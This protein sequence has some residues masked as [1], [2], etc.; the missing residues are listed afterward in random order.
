MTLR[1]L[2]LTAVAAA[3]LSITPAHAAFHL[4]R[5]DQIYSNSDGSVQYIVIRES[6]GTN[7]ENFWAG[8][9]LRTTNAAG[10]VKSFQFPSNLPSSNTASRSVL[11]ATP[12]FAAMNL[13][14]P[15]FT[16]PARF[17]P[18][19]GGTLDYASGT[20]RINLPPLPTDGATAIDRNG[21]PVPGTPKNFSNATGTMT[22]MVVTSVEFYNASLDHYFISALAPDIDALDSGRISGWARTG[23]VFGVFPSQIA[24]GAGVT[25][26]CRIIIPPPH[27][28]SHFFGRSLQ[29]CTD[30]LAKFPFMSQETANAFFITLPVAG[31]CPAGT[32][33]VY[34]VFSNRVD[35]NHRYM[36]DRTLRDQMAAMGWT[37][38]GDGP[39][40]VVMCAPPAP[41]ATVS[42]AAAMDSGMP[43]PP[44]YG[45]YGGP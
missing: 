31:V 40:F 43:M 42:A 25:P 35:A 12:G 41:A 5:I 3:T 15:D 27:G 28:D 23:R 4:F 21:T 14:T 11:I 26:V 34:R 37:V 10:V 18:T 32:T 24:G 1:S 30:T 36:I 7:G 13:I 29:E 17:V 39:D 2:L 19:D 33:P 9:L 22:A 20:D 16:I 6:T 44:G 8:N 45:G 38:E